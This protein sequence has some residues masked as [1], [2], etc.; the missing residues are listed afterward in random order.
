MRLI[1]IFVRVYQNYDMKEES[2]EKLAHLDA[3][4]RLFYVYICTYLSKS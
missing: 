1:F 4:E 2:L 3:Q